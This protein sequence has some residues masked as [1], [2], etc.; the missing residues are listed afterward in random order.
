MRYFVDTEFTD[1]GE[2]FEL[3]SIAVVCEDGREYYAAVQGYDSSALTP[4]IEEHVL[5][6]LP[7]QGDPSWKSRLQIRDDL[8][9][10]VS[11][12]DIEFWTMCAWAD[13]SLVVR[14]FGRFEDVP[15]TWP[16]ACWDLWQLEAELG[17]TRAERLPEPEGVHN[18]LIDARYHHRI[19]ESL[20]SV[21]SRRAAQL[22]QA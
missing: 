16:M 6:N 19:H 8:A 20:R 1:D 7:P 9:A 13:W 3:I 21:Q 11:G 12:S 10:F 17:V 14:L 22:H 5:P 15:E 4:W 2:R 18:A